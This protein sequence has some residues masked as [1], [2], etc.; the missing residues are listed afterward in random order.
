MALSDADA[1]RLVTLQAAYD[2]L[3]SGQALARVEWNGRVTSY[4][5]GD[6]ASLL[7][8]INAL[9]AQEAAS[10]ASGRRAGAIRFRF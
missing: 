2:A 7:A 6:T 9:K 10:S 8:T 4:N 5:K 1:A 3:I